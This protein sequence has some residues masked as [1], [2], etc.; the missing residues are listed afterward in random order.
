MNKCKDE[1]SDMDLCSKRKVNKVSYCSGN[2][3]VIVH[4]FQK[5]WDF[6]LDPGLLTG[7]KME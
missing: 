6:S 3:N 7:F 1:S 2:Q 4:F 5:L